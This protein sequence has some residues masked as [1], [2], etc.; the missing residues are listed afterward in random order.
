MKILSLN[1]QIGTKRLEVVADFLNSESF[2]H[3]FLQEVTI[4]GTTN[5][6]DTINSLLLKPFRSTKTDTVETYTT[7]RG[8]RY[9]QGMSVLSRSDK[10]ITKPIELSPVRGDKHKRIAQHIV[11]EYH[12]GPCQPEHSHIDTA[13]DFI[14]AHFANKASNESQLRQVVN[15]A[16]DNYLYPIILG[17]FNMSLAKF[18]ETKRFW[19]KAYESS[20]EFLKYTSYPGSDEFAQIDICLLPKG[21]LFTN[22]STFGGMSDHNAVLYEIDDSQF[23]DGDTLQYIYLSGSAKHTSAVVKQK[24]DKS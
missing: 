17:D 24:E 1:L 8:D 11:A 16:D 10:I 22:I 3:V 9:T 14:H 23:D 21:M 7:S 13:Y 6:A 19:G 5:S 12:C 20:V 4:D 18:Y 15:Y 2:D